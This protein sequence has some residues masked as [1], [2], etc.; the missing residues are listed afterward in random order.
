MKLIRTV[1]V[2][3]V[4]I[5]GSENIQTPSVFSHFMLQPFAEM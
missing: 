4:N 1:N 5:E 3:T 2:A